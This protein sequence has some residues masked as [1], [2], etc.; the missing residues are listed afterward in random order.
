VKYQFRRCDPQGRCYDTG[1]NLLPNPTFESGIPPWR[2]YDSTV[3]RDSSR[4]I[5][6]SWSL[7]VVT[8]GQHDQEGFDLKDPSQPAVQPGTP[9]TFSVWVYSVQARAFRLGFDENVTSDGS[10]WLGNQW[11]MV[12]HPGGGWSLLGFTATTGATTHFVNPFVDFWPKKTQTTFWVDSLALVKSGPT[13]TSTYALSPFDIWSKIRVA[14]TASNAAG[15]TTAT[16]A[17][18]PNVG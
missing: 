11:R 15:S 5:G 10:H 7:R 17:P 2:A 3:S 8:A 14:V 6:G 12:G 13:D 16:S 1:P 18:T 9:Y 4:S